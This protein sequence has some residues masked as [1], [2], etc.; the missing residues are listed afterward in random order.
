MSTLVRY[1]VQH[2][3]AVVTIDNPPVNALGPGVLEGIERAVARGAEDAAV[4]AIVLAGAGGRFVAGADIRIF[5][6]LKTRE[7][8]LERSGRTHA[9]LRRLEDC[10]KPL[11]AAIDGHALGG[12]LELAM[13]CHYRVASPGAKVGQPEVSLGLIPGAGGTQRLPRLCGAKTALELCT[14]GKP[15]SAARALDEGIVDRI[16]TDGLAGTAAAFARERAAAGEVRR[17]R[18]L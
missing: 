12:G 3:V 6:T 18:D 7:Q 9:L 13:A 8:S 17:T 10:A 11:V 1:D 16:A 5:D 15:V 4:D 2:R 14:T